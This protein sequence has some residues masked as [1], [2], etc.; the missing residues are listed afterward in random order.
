MGTRALIHVKDS[1]IKSRTLVTIYRQYD[2]YPSGLGVDIKTILNEGDVGIINGI[3]DHEAPIYFNGMGCLAAWLIK[4]LKE[5]IGNVYIV[6]PSGKDMGE[7]YTYTLYRDE[8]RLFIKA[9]GWEGKTFYDG[10][11]SKFVGGE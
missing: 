2:G 3:G 4:W 10:D 6:T 5:E 8:Q 11:L 7:E 1:G 9:Q